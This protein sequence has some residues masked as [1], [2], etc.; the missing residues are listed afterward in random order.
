MREGNRDKARGQRLEQAI[1]ANGQRKMMAI[2][3]EL[4][5]SPAALSK[6]KNGG[7]MS[8]EHACKMADLLDVSLDWLL[9]GRNVPDWMREDQ[10]GAEEIRLLSQLKERSPRIMHLIFELVCEIPRQPATR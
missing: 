3:A 5:V 2:A 1:H 4:G 6:W 9:M 7:T 8:T 10:I